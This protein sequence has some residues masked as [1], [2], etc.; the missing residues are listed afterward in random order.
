M[1]PTTW[2]RFVAGL[3]ARLRLVHKGCLK[4]KFRPII[5]WLE[6]CAN[7]KLQNYGVRVDLAMFQARVDGYCQYGLVIYS[8]EEV[9]HVSFEY[10]N[11]AH[12]NEQHSRYAE[13]T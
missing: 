9:D 4:R 2:Y 3:N 12:Q 5:E 10:P 13:Y 7:T 11:E 6:T 1:P 8:A